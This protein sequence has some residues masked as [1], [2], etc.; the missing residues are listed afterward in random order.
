MIILKHTTIFYLY[1][2]ASAFF[3]KGSILL[4]ISYPQI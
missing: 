2:E 1:V 3:V 4:S